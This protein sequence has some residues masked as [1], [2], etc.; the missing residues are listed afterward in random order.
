MEN[1]PSFEKAEEI[2]WKIINLLEKEDN[3]SILE[4][5]IAVGSV[6]AFG[7]YK[8]GISENEEDRYLEKL[9]ESVKRARNIY[10]N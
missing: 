9:I 5:F 10:A 4:V 7:I 1:D 8:S 3:S 6:L 2:G